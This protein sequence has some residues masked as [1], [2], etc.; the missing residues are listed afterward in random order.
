MIQKTLSLTNPTLI[1]NSIEAVLKIDENLMME[2]FENE[3]IQAL[4]NII[5]NSKDALS[6]ESLQDIEKYLFI[7]IGENDGKIEIV[8]RDNAGGIPEEIVTKIF[9]PYFTTKHQSFGTGL[10]LSMTYQIITKRHNGTIKATTDDFEYKGNSYRGASFLISFS[11]SNTG[12]KRLD[13]K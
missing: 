2:G 13:K 4:I 7:S 9:E 3:L 8:L 12:E 10:G 11:S 5:N 1:M 6:D